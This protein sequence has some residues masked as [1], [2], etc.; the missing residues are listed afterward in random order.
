MKLSE[1]RPCDNCGGQIVP[2]FYVARVSLAMFMSQESNHVI[3]MAQMFGGLTRPGVLAVAEAMA[4]E[5][6][7]I[8]ILGD[9]EQG[10]MTEIILCQE[11]HSMKDLNLA[12]L[13]EKVS[14]TRKEAHR[15]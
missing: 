5:A 7:C 2:L 13:A 9:E 11:C 6:D 3:G 12:M 15:Q 1:I 10:L 8:K 14:N 4:P